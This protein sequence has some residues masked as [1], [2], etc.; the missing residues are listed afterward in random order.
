MNPSGIFRT[1]SILE[2]QREL[3]A[4]ASAGVSLKRHLGPVHLILLGI[5][6]LI[7]AGI[8]SLTGMAA[9][10]YAGP[11]IVYSFLISAVACALA[12]LCYAEFASM[13]PVSGSAYTYAYTTLGEYFA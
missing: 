10:H 1:K 8:F 4:G 2:I 11:G 9:G 5:G 3:A 13:V 12:G 6:V 7:G